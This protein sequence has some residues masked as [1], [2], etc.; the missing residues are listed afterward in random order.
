MVERVLGREIWS[1][2]I[3]VTV[4]YKDLEIRVMGHGSAQSFLSLTVTDS[5]PYILQQPY[6]GQPDQRTVTNPV[7]P[8]GGSVTLNV[9]ARGSLPLSYQWRFNGN[10]L[11]GATN[12][13]LALSNLRYDQT[14][15]YNVAISNAFGGVISDKALVNVVQVFVWTD[16]LTGTTTSTIKN[17]PIN[18]TNVVAAAAGYN[19]VLVLQANGRVA[20]WIGEATLTS[21]TYVPASVTNVAAIA[22]GGNC[23]MALR[24]N[25]TVVAWGNNSFGQTNVPAGLSDVVAIAVGGSHCLAVKTNGSVTGWG[26]NGYGQTTVPTGLTNVVAVAAGENHSLALRADGT[27]AAW[28]N[29]SLGQTTVPVGLSNVIALAASGGQSLAV[30]VDGTAVVWGRNRYGTATQNGWTNLVAIAAV[31]YRSLGLRSDGSI[32]P[33]YAAQPPVGIQGLSNVVA[34][35]AG[36]PRV[37]TA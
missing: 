15:Y 5:P 17:V 24:T 20:T 25:G 28:G 36:G 26:I 13:T 4:G 3:K 21:L 19:H 9:G 2:Q 29:S 37:L 14:G 1:T 35:T 11:P 16:G 12:T 8:I 7:V 23:S 10:D 33:P 6:S 22:A 18:L 30:R 32:V 34:I 31:D 27:V